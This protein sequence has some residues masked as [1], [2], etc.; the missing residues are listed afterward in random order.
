MK[1]IFILCVCVVCFLLVGC[2]CGRYKKA[3]ERREYLLNQRTEKQ[4][5]LTEAK[6][7]SDQT[8]KEGLKKELNK[9]NEALGKIEKIWRFY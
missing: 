7:N 1:K 5:E 8:K 6:K 9:I 3:K 2:E 4:Q